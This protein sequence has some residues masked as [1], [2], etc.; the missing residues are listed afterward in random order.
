[1]ESGWKP[2]SSAS[3]SKSLPVGSATSAHT[4]LRFSSQYWLNSPAGKSLVNSLDL[5]SRHVVVIT[6]YGFPPALGFASSI[7]VRRPRAA[8]K[9]SRRLGPARAPTLPADFGERLYET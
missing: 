5:L 3:S 1:M 7:L 4:T 8:Q 9:I 2:N 6:S